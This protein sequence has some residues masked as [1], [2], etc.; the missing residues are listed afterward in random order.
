M[1]CSALHGLGTLESC[2]RSGV[3]L[4]WWLQITE[5][6]TQTAKA[7]PTPP[8]HM[9]VKSKLWRAKAVSSYSVIAGSSWMIP[10]LCQV[11]VSLRTFMIKSASLEG[12][13]TRCILIDNW[14]ALSYLL[15]CCSSRMVTGV[16]FPDWVPS[17]QNSA[18]KTRE[19][20]ILLKV[21]INWERKSSSNKQDIF[22]GRKKMRART[23]NPSLLHWDGWYFSLPTL[24]ILGT[25]RMEALISH[26]HLIHFPVGE[27]IHWLSKGREAVWEAPG[28]TW[29]GSGPQMWRETF[30]FPSLWCEISSGWKHPAFLWGEW[31]NPA[32]D[33]LLQAFE[34]VRFKNFMPL[35][36]AMN[37]LMV[38]KRNHRLLFLP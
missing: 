29:Q 9:S 26:S 11:P 34:Y 10:T 21:Q 33:C 25:N 31:A 36:G 20:P 4:F 22:T 35:F 27:P 8:T 23:Q 6:M 12:C 19:G 1:V 13:T 15:L 2:P 30:S 14:F 7:P 28:M 38:G 37:N 3:C 17:S 32:R 24:L 16:H 18:F 5:N